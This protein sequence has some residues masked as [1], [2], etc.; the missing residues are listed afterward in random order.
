[1][2]KLAAFYLRLFSIVFI[3]LVNISLY[4]QKIRVY[5]MVC[6]KFIKKCYF[7]IFSIHWFSKSILF[8]L[9]SKNDKKLLVKLDEVLL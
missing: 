3:A 4:P 2:L 6:F 7:T 5:F 1:M 9:N 8:Y